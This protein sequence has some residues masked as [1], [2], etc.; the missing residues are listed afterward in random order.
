MHVY[1]SSP[2]MF[3]HSTH[4]ELRLLNKVAGEKNVV[5]KSFLGTNMIQY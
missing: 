1:A 3:H 4:Q 5:R 2:Q